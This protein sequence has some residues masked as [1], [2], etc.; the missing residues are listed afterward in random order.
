MEEGR[1]PTTNVDG[2]GTWIYDVE[3]VDELMRKIKANVMRN[4]TKQ[5][6]K[7][8]FVCLIIKILFVSERLAYCCNTAVGNTVGW[9]TTNSHTVGSLFVNIQTETGVSVKR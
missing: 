5:N 4:A 7:N 6:K 3:G 1:G 2:C 8:Y 9:S